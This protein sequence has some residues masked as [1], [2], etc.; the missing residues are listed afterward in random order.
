MK[1]SQA[2]FGEAA[3]CK[4]EDYRRINK[5]LF[6]VISVTFAKL[7]DEQRAKILE[8]KAAFERDFYHAIDENFSKSLA[9][10]T[11]KRSNIDLR[12][13]IFNRLVENTLKS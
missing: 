8:S 13:D 1:L 2:V 12:Y 4:R 11:G 10:G 3:F 7:S 5:A 6:E 9:S